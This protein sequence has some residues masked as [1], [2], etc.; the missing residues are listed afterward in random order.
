MAGC[1]ALQ[2]GRLDL[3]LPLGCP[4]GFSAKR[5]P[6][7]RKRLY[8]D[9]PSLSR[10][11]HLMVLNLAKGA[12]LPL[13]LQEPRLQRKVGQ[14]YPKRVRTHMESESESRARARSMVRGLRSGHWSDYLLP[15][16]RAAW[17]GLKQQRIILEK[18]GWPYVLLEVLQT[19]KN[20]S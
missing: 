1:S 7:Q 2:R 13:H 9:W 19:G 18:T 16:P 3:D 15:L 20:L 5:G 14:V 17:P 12:F 4:L 10:S 11:L 8:I 6:C